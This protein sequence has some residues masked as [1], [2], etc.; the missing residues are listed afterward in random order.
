MGRLIC[1]SSNKIF[2]KTPFF[3]SYTLQN[4][5]PDLAL[6]V[7]QLHSDWTEAVEDEGG[8]RDQHLG[9]CDQEGVILIFIMNITIIIIIIS[10]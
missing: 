4:V 2:Y 10:T 3:D 9:G 1:I 5:P 6:P 7:V 8:Q